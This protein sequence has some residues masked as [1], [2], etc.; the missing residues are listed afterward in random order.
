[1]ASTSVHL[2]AAIVEKLDRLAG[3][4]G[5]WPTGFF[6]PPLRPDE[7]EE[8]RAGGREMEETILAARR[9]RDVPPL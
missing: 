6:E 1:M 4:Q 3:H 2:P 7:V 5:D 8:L 9:E